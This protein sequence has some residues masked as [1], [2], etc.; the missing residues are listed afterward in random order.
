MTSRGNW[1]QT[2][3]GNKFYPLDPRP[4]DFETEDIAHALG[5]ICRYG[6]H[7]AEFYSVA[8]HCIIM[9]YLVP[10]EYA[11]TA[12]MHD[13]AEAYI[14]DL[15]RPIKRMLPEYSVMEDVILLALAQQFPIIL[16]GGGELPDIVN[17]LDAK[18]LVTERNKLMPFTR[19]RWE[20]DDLEV[21]DFPINKFSPLEAKN[22][23]LLRL[24]ELT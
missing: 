11:L 1:I 3:L 21:V 17:E 23:Y 15:P 6:G 18:M 22:Q 16:E 24:R 19:H 10:K 20:Q 5:M 13:A 9:S 8:E 4:E 12:L 2:Y 14:Q 7:V